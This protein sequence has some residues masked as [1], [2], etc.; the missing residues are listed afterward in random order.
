MFANSI[1]ALR[2]AGARSE[3]TIATTRGVFLET[4]QAQLDRPEI[5]AILA[6][7]SI[8]THSDLPKVKTVAIAPLLADAIREF[9]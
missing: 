8:S 1:D 2:E 9:G 6:T 3:M 4:A 7:D 5:Q